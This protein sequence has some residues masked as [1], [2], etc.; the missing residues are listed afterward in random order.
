MKER[1]ILYA[2]EGKIL[3]NGE[4]YGKI[5]YLAE[6]A[7]PN[8]FYEITEDEYIKICREN[9]NQDKALDV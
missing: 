2:D 4:A 5:I 6:G 7:S 8:D 3:S 1:S 9:K